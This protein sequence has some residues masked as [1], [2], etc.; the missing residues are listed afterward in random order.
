MHKEFE[1]ILASD[2]D[3]N[4]ENACP[5]VR[6]TFHAL[7][8]D[9]LHSVP[10]DSLDFSKDLS[11]HDPESFGSLSEEELQH[12]LKRALRICNLNL[13]GCSRKNRI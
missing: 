12:T 5:E 7:P 3:F 11:D 6:P 1:S 4:L 9:A 2:L 8:L 10:P 13:C